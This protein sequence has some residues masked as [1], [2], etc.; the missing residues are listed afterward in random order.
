MQALLLSCW[1]CI[2]VHVHIPTWPACL[3]I[4]LH[5]LPRCDAWEYIQH[6]A[7]ASAHKHSARAEHAHLSVCMW[8]YPCGHG[9]YKVFMRH[10]LRPSADSSFA[11][12]ATK[13]CMFAFTTC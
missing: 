1:C 4:P 6:A 12:L 3:R 13:R 8:Q 9:M 10:Q 2:V 5:P 11:R 7:L